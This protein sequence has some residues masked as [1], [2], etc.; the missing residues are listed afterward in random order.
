MFRIDDPS[1]ATTLPVPEAAGTERF[2]TEGVPGVTA[3]TLVRASFLNMIQEEL[4]AIVVAGGL[5]PSKTNYTQLLTALRSAG[6]FQ[7][8]PQFDATTKVATMEAVKRA[9][10]GFSGYS[11]VG[12]SRSLLAS[13]AGKLL[14]IGGAGVTLTLPTPTSLGFKLG[15]AFTVFTSAPAG[16][17]IVPGAGATLTSD[18]TNTTASIVI[19]PNQ[20]ATFVASS[21]LLTW[22]MVN[23]TAELG[24]N[25]DFAATK[26]ATGESVSPNGMRKKWGSATLPNTGSSAS[27][28]AI[29]FASAFPVAVTGIKLT[30]IGLANSSSGFTPVMRPTSISA[31]GFTAVGDLNNAASYNQTV[32]FY[33]EVEGY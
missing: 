28:F 5:T 31:S 15:D 24:R 14:F 29:S 6:V 23:S 13:D 21:D 8:A 30:P 10:G 7:T 1:A 33:W 12:A 3:A 32:L 27:S 11:G 2:F 19:K 9:A 4:R 26:A 18:G 16:S 25:P 17:S 20:T 22:Q